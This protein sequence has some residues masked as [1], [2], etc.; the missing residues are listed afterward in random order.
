M[1]TLVRFAPSSVTQVPDPCLRTASLAIPYDSMGDNL[2]AALS[3]VEVREDGP[4]VLTETY[5]GFTDHTTRGGATLSLRLSRTIFCA[6]SKNLN[7]ELKELRTA[8][9]LE[10]HFSRRD[11][12]TIFANRGWFGENLVGV[13][14]ASQHF[15]QRE[16]I[17]L[18]LGEA[19][20][21]AGMIKSPSRFSPFE[22]PDRALQ[23]RNEVLGAMVEAHFIDAEKAETAK[24]LGI[25]PKRTD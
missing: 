12:F 21:L 1:K 17:Q 10:R 25:L 11:L 13:E 6:P 16:P 5:R 3:A 24:A 9:Q 19:A 8:V 14:A 2:R 15:F 20:L 4:G 7:R 18:R 22:H 23:R